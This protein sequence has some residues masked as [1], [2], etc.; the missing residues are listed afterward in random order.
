M[1]KTF[2][3]DL[4]KQKKENFLRFKKK[5]KKRLIEIEPQSDFIKKKRNVEEYNYSY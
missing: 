3:G 4:R 2:R 1:S 5:R